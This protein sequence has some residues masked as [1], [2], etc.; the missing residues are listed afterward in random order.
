MAT[1]SIA[2]AFLIVS[3]YEWVALQDSSEQKQKARLYL[4]SFPGSPEQVKGRQAGIF[5]H[6]STG[7]L[8]ASTSIHSHESKGH[9]C[10]QSPGHVC[11]C[12]HVKNIA[13]CF[14]LALL[15]RVWEQG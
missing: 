4:D 6:V 12:S 8:D 9:C 1:R 10:Y 15:G 5:L 13:T 11:Q 2:N 3:I 14:L 7:D